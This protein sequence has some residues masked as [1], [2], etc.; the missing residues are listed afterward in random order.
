MSVRRMDTSSRSRSTAS[1]SR[2]VRSEA[3][4]VVQL[5]T[6]R[7]D[8]PIPPILIRLLHR[9]RDR[10]S[11]EEALVPWV[12]MLPEVQEVRRVQQVH[13]HAVDALRG[14][15]VAGEGALPLVRSSS[16]SR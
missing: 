1:A 7:L 15:L 10:R 9:M 14:V 8:N 3:D 6:R 11:R 13:Q 2:C 5:W 4:A 16:R 12:Q